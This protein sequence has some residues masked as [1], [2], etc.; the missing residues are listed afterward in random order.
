VRR[1]NNPLSARVRFDKLQF[2]PLD[3]T[4]ELTEL[5]RTKEGERVTERQNWWQGLSI[6]LLM[7]GITD[8]LTACYGTHVVATVCRT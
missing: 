2:L 1:N 8:K 7:M 3:A 5:C 6:F 4:T